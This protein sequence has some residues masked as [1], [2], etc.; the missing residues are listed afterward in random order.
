MN[1][2]ENL[3]I[4]I[5]RGVSVSKFIEILNLYDSNKRFIRFKVPGI[6]KELKYAKIYDDKY[7]RLIIEVLE[8]EENGDS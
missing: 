6:N 8:G 2:Q 4:N 1:K 5:N 7:G 3:E